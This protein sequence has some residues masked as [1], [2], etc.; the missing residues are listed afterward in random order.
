MHGSAAAARVPSRA[1]PQPEVRRRQTTL[2][3]PGSRRV[4]VKV[5]VAWPSPP[6][7]WH[8]TVRETRW[9]PPDTI[10][11][12]ADRHRR[13]RDRRVDSRPPSIRGCVGRPGIVNGAITGDWRG[14]LTSENPFS[15]RFLISSS[16][17][18]HTPSLWVFIRAV[19]AETTP[20]ASPPTLPIL[21]NP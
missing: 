7:R 20:S 5:G 17:I 12:M 19:L 6:A 14:T 11:E 8:G 13:R 4:N 9:T 16:F 10:S 2:R 15:T 3:H 21:P 1:Q 18:R